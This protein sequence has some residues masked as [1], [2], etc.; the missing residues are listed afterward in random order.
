MPRRRMPSCSPASS[1]SSGG[2]KYISPPSSPPMGEVPK[3]VA[4]VCEEL[5]Y[6]SQELGRCLCDVSP[7]LRRL[8]DAARDELRKDVV[9]GAELIS[10]GSVDLSEMQL[11]FLEEL[12]PRPAWID[13]VAYAAAKIYRGCRDGDLLALALC[14]WALKKWREEPRHPI[15]RLV[16][17]LEP[18]RLY[19]PRDLGEVDRVYLR[20]IWNTARRVEGVR[21]R[22]YGY[23]LIRAAFVLM[24]TRV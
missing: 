8:L 16:E 4:A 1:S 2:L 21:G 11:D 10:A 6:L 19:S 18:T 5:F 9:R 15:W 3:A 14:T 17:S 12:G 22:A 24:A 7:A 23:Q 13:A 20:K